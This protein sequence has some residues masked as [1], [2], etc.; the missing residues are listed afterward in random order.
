MVFGSAHMIRIQPSRA[1]PAAHDPV[2]WGF[3]S[4]WWPIRDVLVLR[5][6]MGAYVLRVLRPDGSQETR[7][8][9]DES[10][11]ADLAIALHDALIVRGWQPWPQPARLWA[12]ES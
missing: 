2:A 4:Q 3:W 9:D 6:R 1:T 12:N 11:L 7:I 5:R 8:C 10:V